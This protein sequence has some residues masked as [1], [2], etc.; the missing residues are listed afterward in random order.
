M[1]RPI[2]VIIRP[3]IWRDITSYFAN[4]KWDPIDVRSVLMTWFKWKAWW[5]PQ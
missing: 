4:I 2:E 3:S 1:F 5:W